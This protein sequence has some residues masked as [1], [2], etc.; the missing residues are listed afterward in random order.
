M[1]KIQLKEMTLLLLGL[2]FHANVFAQITTGSNGFGATSTDYVG[3][4]VNQPF[5]LTIKHE[6]VNQ[7]INFYTNT[8]LN[9]TPLAKLRMDI[10]TDVLKLNQIPFLQNTHNQKSLRIL[11][12]FFST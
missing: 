3:W 6:R 12:G 8:G 7:P 1:K 5:P 4:D 11:R 10:S 9:L 2:A